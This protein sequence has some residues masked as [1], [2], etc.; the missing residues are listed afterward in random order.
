MLQEIYYLF[1]NLH[2]IYPKNNVSIKSGMP[3]DDFV[4]IETLCL[5]SISSYSSHSY[6]GKDGLNHF[7]H[8]TDIR[9][10]SHYSRNLITASN[11]TSSNTLV[12]I[13]VFKCA[14]C[15]HFHAVL[16]CFIFVPYCQYS[17]FFILSVLYELHY[18][19]CTIE[20]LSNKY[21]ISIASIYRWNHRFKSVLTMYTRLRGSS[22]QSFFS[23][24]FND[25]ISLCF[26]YFN[27]CFQAMFQVNRRLSPL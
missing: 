17:L 3:L 13:P 21:Q 15:G 27:L 23:E 19:S 26:D 10:Y 9:L 2:K 12:E 11:Y 1:K 14:V 18:S 20:Q 22:M 7:C 4:Q 16:P 5:N 24:C 25:F 6:K 8:G